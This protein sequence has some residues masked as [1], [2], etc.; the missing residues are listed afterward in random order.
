MIAPV[1]SNLAR[2]PKSLAFRV[3]EAPNG[4][5]CIVWEGECPLQASDLLSA[6]GGGA[7]MQAEEWLRD[8]LSGGPVAQREVERRASAHGIA[9]GTLARAKTA[10]GAES[11]RTGYGGTGEWTWQLA[12]DSAHAGPELGALHQ[13][14]AIGAQPAKLSTYVGAPNVLNP[15]TTQLSTF[16]DG[17]KGDQSVELSA[18]DEATKD[19]QICDGPGEHLWATEHSPDSSSGFLPDEEDPFAD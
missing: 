12:D 10:V 2:M 8:M 3:T 18:F 14:H 17:L 19:D 7:R 11:K 6:A 4:A 16:D 13:G 5:G 1:K 15:V 9:K